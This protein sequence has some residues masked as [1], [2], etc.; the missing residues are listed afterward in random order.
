M[1]WLAAPWLLAALAIAI[2]I[3]Y[4]LRRNSPPDVIRVGSVADLVTGAAVTN[5]R[6]PRDLWLLAVRCA[7]LGLVAAAL[8]QPRV[9]DRRPGRR[10]VVAP[11]GN[12]P[13]VDSL[14][15]A[16]A[17][18][19]PA[20][21]SA[22]PWSAAIRAAWNTARADTVLLV[23][24]DDAARY[25]GP[26]PLVP[27]AVLPVGVAA[28]ES[29]PGPPLHQAAPRTSPSADPRDASRAALPLWWMALGLVLLER[30]MARR[31]P[32]AG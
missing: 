29:L 11:A 15:E 6:V 9:V 13:V 27:R 28:P 26:R 23:V 17:T 30:V 2:P 12:W 16:G 20:V 5:R 19:L 24:P 22:S 32:D 1:Q 18:T 14:R 31:S 3:V 10:V 25:L 4:H 8:A 21:T 7:L